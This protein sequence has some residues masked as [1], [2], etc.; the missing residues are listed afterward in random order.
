MCNFYEHKFP[1]YS[2]HFFQELCCIRAVGSFFMVG[3][4]W[5][6]ELSKNVAHHGSLTMKKKKKKYR[7]NILKQ[8]HK[9]RNVNQSINDSNSH[10]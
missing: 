4:G 9:K 10:I 5:N 7:L 1:T 3:G 2:N 6:G 8:S